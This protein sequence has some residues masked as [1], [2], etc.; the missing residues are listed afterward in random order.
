MF[1]GIMQ[2][3]MMTSKMGDSHLGRFA[4]IEEDENLHAEREVLLS[5]VVP[6]G[7]KFYMCELQSLVTYDFEDLT[8]TTSTMHFGRCLRIGLLLFSIWCSKRLVER[9]VHIWFYDLESMLILPMKEN[10]VSPI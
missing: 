7:Q 10:R 8:W 5:F 1:T 6:P 4:G 3:R 2:I 9:S